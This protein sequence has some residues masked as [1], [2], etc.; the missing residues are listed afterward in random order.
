[1]KEGK[2]SEKRNKRDEKIKNWGEGKVRRDERNTKEINRKVKGPK[3]EK[4]DQTVRV[5]SAVRAP[6]WF[7]RVLTM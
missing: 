2:K 1:M 5:R 3:S 4:K 7:L 6:A